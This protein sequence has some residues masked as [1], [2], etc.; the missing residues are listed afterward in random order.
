MPLP[1]PNNG[2]EKNDFISRCTSE[3]SDMGEFN[4]N[5]QR[6]AVCYSQWKRANEDI[7]RKIDEY[8][9]SEEK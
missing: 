1:T 2:E 5:K 7:V 4:D 3:I 8:L 9:E 6:V